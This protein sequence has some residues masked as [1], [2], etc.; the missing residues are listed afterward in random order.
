M[1]D[2]PISIFQHLAR[3][4]T[5]GSRG[6]LIPRQAILPD[7]SIRS[8]ANCAYSLSG[9]PKY[10]RNHC[11]GVSADMNQHCGLPGNKLREFPLDKLYDI[12]NELA[13]AEER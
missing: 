10:A 13:P 11:A 2:R 12:S 6:R 4:R 7:R 3:R 9:A 1:G 8:S 5:P